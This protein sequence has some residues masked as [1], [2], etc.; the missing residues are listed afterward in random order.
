V[1]TQ[2]G[3]LAPTAMTYDAHGRLA[4]I[5]QGA[6]AEART[7]T[8]SY[9]TL[10]NLATITDAAGRQVSFGYDAAGRMT[11]QTLAD[12]RVIA[13]AYDE[14]GNLTALTPPGRPSH[15]FDYTPVDLQ[16]VYA[17]PVTPNTLTPNTLYSYNRPTGT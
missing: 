3:N 6:G 13:F 4:T 7:T 14:N 10:G 9:D 12:G 17:P 2:L 1:Q 5:T 16:S 8:F 11:S 15:G